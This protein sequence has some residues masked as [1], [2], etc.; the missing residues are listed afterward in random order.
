MLYIGIC[1]YG[2]SH[3]TYTYFKRLN[4]EETNNDFQS[5]SCDKVKKKTINSIT[6]FSYPTLVGVYVSLDARNDCLTKSVD[7]MS[8][9]SAVLLK[10][11][12]NTSGGGNESTSHRISA[13]SLRA[14]P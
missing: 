8:I 1:F 11:H 12:L 2:K 10:D 9:I 13:A 14:T 5:V 7:G 3:K 4:K 6:S